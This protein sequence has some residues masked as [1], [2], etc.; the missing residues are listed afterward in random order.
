VSRGSLSVQR[1]TA[2]HYRLLDIV[3]GLA[4]LWVFTYHYPRWDE[5]RENL[6]VVWNLVEKGYL[7]VPLFFVVSG[8]CMMASARSAIRRN[9]STANYMKRRLSRIYPPF[10]LSILAVLA[11][12]WV[13]ALI[14]QLKSGSFEQPNP[15]YMGFDSLDWLKYFSMAQIFEPG[16]DQ[17]ES[18]F[19]AVNA[20]YWTLAL[21]VQFYL[22]I[23]LGL[24]RRRFLMPVLGVTTL[25]GI[26][27]AFQ[28]GMY[29]T[30][31][32]LP[33]WPMFAMGVALFLVFEK[34]WEPRASR[35]GVVF[36]LSVFAAGL[37]VI[38]FGLAD[39]HAQAFAG[40]STV[41][42]VFLR[43]IDNWLDK[44]LK[45]VLAWFRS[46]LVGLGKISYSL[47]L[48]HAKVMVLVLMFVTQMGIARL[49]LTGM[50]ITIVATTLATYPFY[51]LCE[52]PFILKAPKRALP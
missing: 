6:P 38:G 18:K 8:Y 31:I 30:G 15:R 14:S 7:G 36:G 43:P 28:P 37:G 1:P 40:L 5:L 42:L 51:R 33:Y 23:G 2:L 19:A 27:A 29:L 3:R 10:I 9:E 45:G 46:G 20:V 4:A 16:F 22:V 44:P 13:M 26:A 12:P 50:L 34:G 11:L 52:V 21:E 17:I 35:G 39:M 32:F 49:S 25:L 47:Y 48:M 41:G 24:L